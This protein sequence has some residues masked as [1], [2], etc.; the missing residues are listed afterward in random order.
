MARPRFGISWLAAQAL[1]FSSRYGEVMELP[2]EARRQVV[3]AQLVAK[4][5]QI[6]VGAEPDDLEPGHPGEVLPFPGRYRL[7][8]RRVVGAA[9]FD[10][11]LRAALEVRAR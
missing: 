10:P 5:P 4:R 1:S 7:A 6:E 11:P 8:E 9:R 2:P 3:P